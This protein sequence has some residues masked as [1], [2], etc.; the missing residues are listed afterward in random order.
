QS[1]GGHAIMEAIDHHQEAIGIM[2]ISSPAFSLK[3]L[4]EAFSPDPTDGLLFKG[5]L[6]EEEINRFSLAFVHDKESSSTNAIKSHIR[7]TDGRF[8]EAL[9]ESIQRGDLINELEMLKLSK[10][11]TAVL[12]GVNDDLLNY[13]Y[14]DRLDAKK[15]WQERVIDFDN[16]GHSIPLEN[17]NAFVAMAGEFFA[18]VF[19][20]IAKE[21]K[22]ALSV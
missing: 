10:V 19:E 14:Y 3:S 2:L 12:R 1:V 9:G 21:K 16:C 22:E 4:S 15:F 5:A 7:Q 8:R 6:D 11:P 20:S 17:P 13:D 18:H